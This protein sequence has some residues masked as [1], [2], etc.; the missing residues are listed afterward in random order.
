MLFCR[1]AC[2]SAGLSSWPH[3][4]LSGACTVSNRFLTLRS[5]RCPSCHLACITAQTAEGWDKILTGCPGPG[6]FASPTSEIWGVAASPR[7][8]RWSPGPGRTTSVF[9]R[10]CSRHL[11]EESSIAPT[12]KRTRAAVVARSSGALRQPSLSPDAPAATQNDRLSRIWPS[13]PWPQPV[14][15]HSSRKRLSDALAPLWSINPQVQP[16][17]EVVED[18]RCHH[19]VPDMEDVS[20]CSKTAP[21]GGRM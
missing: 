20:L 5:R 8:S 1:H 10:W 6:R 2:P 9:Q 14:F 17:L 19:P 12:G 13:T 3:H 21:P 15:T 16:T 11:V 18:L 7:L 4:V